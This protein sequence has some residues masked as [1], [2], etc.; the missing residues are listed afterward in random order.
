MNNSKLDNKIQAQLNAFYDIVNS[1]KNQSGEVDNN[2][3]NQL[4]LIKERL[5]KLYNQKSQEIPLKSNDKGNILNI[6]IKE[7]EFYNQTNVELE[8]ISTL[9]C[10]LLNMEILIDN[11]Y[12]LL[13][14]VNI[15]D[16][17]F[18]KYEPILNNRALL[19]IAVKKYPNNRNF[20]AVYNHFTN[21]AE[22]E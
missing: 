15:S 3:L 1:E 10:D 11:D 14:L 13:E 20:R 17:M 5:A 7:L 16:E 22:S 4:R 21:Q 12:L 6:Q 8:D 9:F 2:T 18:D 19:T